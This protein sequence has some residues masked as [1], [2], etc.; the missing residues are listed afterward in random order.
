[1]ANSIIVFYLAFHGATNS[2]GAAASSNTNGIRSLP[3][4]GAIRWDAWFAGNDYEKNL[5]PKQWNNR[6]PFYAQVASDGNVSVRSDSQEV[7]DKEIG[8]A[9]EAGLDYWA[10]CYYDAKPDPSVARFNYGLNRYLS[11]KKKEGMNFCLILQPNY[12]GSKAEWRKTI[13]QFVKYF[14]EPTYQKVASGRPLVFIFDAGSLTK[15]AGSDEGVKEAF[16]ELDRAAI[17]A[18]LKEP[19]VVAQATSVASD[20]WLANRFGLDAISAYTLP[21]KGPDVEY[22]YL[23]LARA[24]RKFWDESKSTAKQIIPIVNVGWD[25]R[26]RRTSSEEAVKLRGPWYTLPTPGELA[27]HLYTAI[28]W[29]KNNPESAEAN[30]VI[31]YAWNESDEGGWLVPTLAEG[32]ARL[33]AVKAALQMR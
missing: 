30:A 31:I 10:F 29:V 24:N 22:P 27:I 6:L 2:C 25:N 11:S 17:N 12:I 28:Q 23:D 15:W 8:F 16:E 14:K 13:Q 9:K 7:I 5:A 18:G 3:V 26:P 19:Y 4:V 1:V 21:E 20:A 32:N 33:Q